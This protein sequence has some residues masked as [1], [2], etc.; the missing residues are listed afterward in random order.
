MRYSIAASI[1]ALCLIG[2][3]ALAQDSAMKG[4]APDLSALPQACREALKDVRMPA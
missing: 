3:P 1:A 2:T 4:M